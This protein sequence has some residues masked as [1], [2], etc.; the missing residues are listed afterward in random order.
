MNNFIKDN[1]KTN[2]SYIT[3]KSQVYNVLLADI[4]SYS[5]IWKYKFRYITSVAILLVFIDL[6][7]YRYW[8]FEPELLLIMAIVSFIFLC[9]FNL[10]SIFV[11]SANTSAEANKKAYLEKVHTIQKI[12]AMVMPYYTRASRATHIINDQ[13]VNVM[14]LYNLNNL[15]DIKPNIF[16]RN[17]MQAEL[18][19]LKSMLLTN[20][21]ERNHARYLSNSIS[22]TSLLENNH[23]LN[24]IEQ[25]RD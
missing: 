14:N 3:L 13:K 24:K 19:S 21:H 2:I 4:T 20:F 22:L 23:S 9:V 7:K 8:T 12:H 16:L 25:W 15:R 17:G 1:N 6:F 10:A 11:V 18:I 5:T